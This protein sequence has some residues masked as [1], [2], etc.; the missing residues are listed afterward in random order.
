MANDPEAKRLEDWKTAS[1]GVPRET[2]LTKWVPAA[3]HALQ[4]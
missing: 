2:S 1:N 3:N 4:L